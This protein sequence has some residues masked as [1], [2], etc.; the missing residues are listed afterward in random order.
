MQYK[1][2]KVWDAMYIAILFK[3]LV[4][5]IPEMAKKEPNLEQFFVNI[6]GWITRQDGIVYVAL[7]EGKIIGFMLT[8]IVKETYNPLK[9]HSFCELIYIEPDYRNGEVSDKLIE[10]S[11]MKANT[12]GVSSHEFITEYREGLIKAWSKKGYKPVQIIFN[13][14][15]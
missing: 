8:Y 15:V 7:D 13:Q 3:K 9:T 2:A 12:F 4:E 5:G 10:L 1:E 6:I 14:E 11:K